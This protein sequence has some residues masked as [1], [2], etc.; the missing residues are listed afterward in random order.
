MKQRCLLKRFAALVA[1]MVISFSLAVPAF[2]AGSDVHLISRDFPSLEEFKK[3]PNQWYLCRESSAS[4]AAYVLFA[5]APTSWDSDGFPTSVWSLKPLNN[6][7]STFVITPA[8]STDGVYQYTFHYIDTGVDA[9]WLTKYSVPIG[10]DAGSLLFFPSSS[11]T[12]SALKDGAKASF[13]LT[14]TDYVP[15]SGQFALSSTGHG[16][17]SAGDVSSAI[18]WYSRDFGN[19]HVPFGRVPH[20]SSYSTRN[21]L[22]PIKLSDFYTSFYTVGNWDFGKFPFSVQTNSRNVRFNA[23]YDSTPTASSAS[24]K[25]L[26]FLPAI[27]FTPDTFEM[28]F[29]TGYRNGGWFPGDEDLQKELVNDFGV[30]SNTLKDSKSSLD[31]WNSTSSIDLDV[32]SG[33]FGFLTGIF[34]NLGTFL[35]SVSLLCFG[36]VVLR[37][38]IRKAVDG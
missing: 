27:H 16:Y 12:I 20:P 29:G 5:Y 9:M 18:L 33:A 10:P 34:Q 25:Q 13:L 1:A 31:S 15:D 26:V 14:T 3:H 8:T 19:N 6:F 17:Y 35:F 36:A 7:S 21:S 23:V 24:Y 30:D 4:S 2:A 11:D 38:L 32:A 37:M 28:L 22:N